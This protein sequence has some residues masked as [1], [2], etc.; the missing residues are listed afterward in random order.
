[1]RHRIR[2]SRCERG[3][4][5]DGLCNGGLMA[6]RG[7]TALAI[8]ERIGI[9]TARANSISPTRVRDRPAADLKAVAIETEE[10]EVRGSI[11]GA[12]GEPS[13]LAAAPARRRAAP[14]VTLVAPGTVFS[15]AD[16]TLEAT[17]WSSPRGVGPGVTVEDNAVNPF[18]LPSHGRMWQGRAGRTICA[19]AAGA[20][21]G[22]DVHIGNF[23]EVK[24]A[25]IEA[26]A[27]A[28]HFAYIGERGSAPARIRCR[29]IVLQLRRGRQAPLISARALH[30]LR[31]RRCRARQD[32]RRRLCGDRRR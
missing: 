26:G 32:R 1:M 12:A 16:T 17:L 14:G 13:S 29:A 10:D 30:R 2:E 28:N 7:A 6:F 18:V 3:R 23:V 9:I 31:T 25:T 22:G 24:E 15:S 21:L 11:Q 27:K 20:W 8:L 19:A 4:A 5:R